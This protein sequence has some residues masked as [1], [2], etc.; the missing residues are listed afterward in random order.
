MSD[1]LLTSVD[2]EKYLSLIN[3]LFTH[4][5]ELAVFGVDGTA[6]F[7]NSAMD[8]SELARAVT[9]PKGHRLA[10]AE[11]WEKVQV[12]KLDD[13][14]TVYSL[15]MVT[16]SDDFLGVLVLIVNQDSL[17]DGVYTFDEFRPLVENLA[18]FIKNECKLTKELNAM[19]NELGERYEELNLV[20]DTDDYV[21]ELDEVHR[22]LKRIVENCVTYLGVSMALLS[23]PRKNI[24][25]SYSDDARPISESKAVIENA[26]NVLYQKLKGSVDSIVLNDL[27]EVQEVCP[28]VTCKILSSPILGA[29]GQ[30]DGIIVTTKNRQSPDYNNS[31]RNLLEVM[32]K[33]VMQV[34]QANYDTLTG[35][36]NRAVF[37]LHVEES[38]LIV[39]QT[40]SIHT[41]LA[42]D[43]DDLQVTNDTFSYQV[44]DNL[45]KTVAGVIQEQVR[46]TD[47]VS[48]IGGDEFG[49]L[50]ENCPLEAG[51]RIANKIRQ[52]I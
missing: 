26:S 39:R 27:V 37:E 19:A 6:V 50:L 4:A 46:D 18:A 20:Y 30:L 41:I 48:R 11:S 7:T 3:G 49:V 42:I 22:S 23:L 29:D 5:C 38:L 25:I 28:G 51:V 33:K 13:G 8:R 52:A 34:I 43:L 40:N 14:K 36:L 47:I 45:I 15:G 21:Q 2:F 35:L 44:G 24:V 16:E 31:D 10:E 12:R 1:N 32:S 9:L 17:P